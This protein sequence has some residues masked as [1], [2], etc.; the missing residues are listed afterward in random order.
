MSRVAQKPLH[1]HHTS[2]FL[3]PAYVLRGGFTRVLSEQKCFHQG[4]KRNVLAASK[5]SRRA[6][7]VEECNELIDSTC[8]RLEVMDK[9]L[10]QK[11][12]AEVRGLE[13]KKGALNRT[14]MFSKAAAGYRNRCKMFEG[15]IAELKP[16]QVLMDQEAIDDLYSGIMIGN[17]KF[18]SLP[19]DK[20]IEKVVELCQKSWVVSGI[21]SP[22]RQQCEPK[23][24]NGYASQICKDLQAQ[25]A[26][27]ADDE[28]AWTQIF[29][30]SW[31]T[32]YIF[33]GT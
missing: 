8:H 23:E 27:Q 18:S 10:I 12:R 19:E 32:F 20:R 33:M 6:C 26:I 2:S 13:A 3:K 11:A 21:L 14:K 28:S 30:H 1:D 17:Y 25:T 16:S 24:G 7:S 4:F 22:K 5:A 15:L 31:V 29:V 9:H